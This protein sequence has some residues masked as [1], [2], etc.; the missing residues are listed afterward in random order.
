MAVLRG[1]MLV[2]CVIGLLFLPM[3]EI[4]HYDS[5]ISRAISDNIRVAREKSEHTDLGT[6]DIDAFTNTEFVFY[7]PPPVTKSL[8]RPSVWYGYQYRS[9][10]YI[11][12]NLS[13]IQVFSY[14]NGANVRIQWLNATVIDGATFDPAGRTWSLREG[15]SMH[16]LEHLE[17]PISD[18]RFLKMGVYESQEIPLNS[19]LVKDDLR[20][21]TGTVRITSDNPIT[22]MHHKLYPTGTKDSDGQDMINY[23]WDGVY[24]AYTSKLFT[25]I[26]RDCWISALEAHTT[27][28][29]W[30][31][32][33]RNDEFT[34]KLDRFEGWSYCR[35]P[36]YQQLGFD[37]D[38]VLISA[39]KPVSIVAGL[40][41]R[42]NFVQVFGKDSRDFHFP[43]FGQILVHAPDG[44]TIDLKDPNGN[45]GSFKGTLK[46]GEFR[47]FDF[48]VMYKLRGYS[49][50]EWATLRSNR[51]VF[52][53]TFANNQWYLDEDYANRIAGE[54]YLMKNRKVTTFYSHGLVPYPADTDFQVPL[55]SRAY[56]TVVNLGS[57]DNDVQVNFSALLMPY[58][59]QMKAYE[60]VTIE[61]S[62]DSY[63]YMNMVLSDTNYMQPPEWTLRDP[64]NRFMLDSVPRIAVDRSLRD[65]IFLSRENMTRG[66]LM[67]VKSDSPVLVFIN[68]DRDTLSSAQGIELIPGLTPP[69]NRRLP[70]IIPGF[71]A[72]S[73][74]VLMVD[75]IAVSWGGRSIGHISLKDEAKAPRKAKASGVG[76]SR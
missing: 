61:F 12:S 13:S 34:V 26:T 52:V 57:D 35:N 75:M 15:H 3:S 66:S 19:W 64:Q 42:Q 7:V 27:V 39:D 14:E 25:R 24:S 69:V 33:D 49:S 58:K 2:A 28:R 68:Y 10:N 44:A 21:L 67:R 50:F 51:P 43:T 65:S 76:N 63:Y 37:D 47:T 60:T 1:V 48:K 30:D 31:F 59:K 18:S 11:M 32:S 8:E 5:P 23:Y 4:L 9:G 46:K 55:Y 73:G 36:I 54:E 6:T 16:W 22:V 17:P 56:V 20:I 53:Y 70:D 45:Q 72:V 74:M 71:V 62:E 38:H 40:Q 41:S 29:I